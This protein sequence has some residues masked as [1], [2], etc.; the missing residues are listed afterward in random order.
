VGRFRLGAEASDERF[1]LQPDLGKGRYGL[2]QRRVD[3]QHM[4][5]LVQLADDLDAE[6]RPVRI[7]CLSAGERH[8][9]CQGEG[10]RTRRPAERLPT[11]W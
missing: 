6:R 3:R 10:P 7:S 11:R 8:R 4:A 5:I 1:P 9:C 2:P